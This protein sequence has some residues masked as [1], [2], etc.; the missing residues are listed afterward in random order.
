[1]T[2]QASQFFSALPQYPANQS[3]EQAARR[4]VK[5]PVE[6][7]PVKRSLGPAA[8]QQPAVDPSCGREAA[9]PERPAPWQE[10]FAN[11]LFLALSPRVKSP[12]RGA[13]SK[14]LEPFERFDIE[15]P[16]GRGKLSATWYPAAGRARGAVLLVHPWIHWGQGYFERRGRI[17]A[18]RTAGYH[19]LTFDLGGFGDSSP[20]ASTFYDRDI[21]HA[22]NELRTRAGGLPTHL[23]GVSSGGYWAHPVLSRV[24]VHGAVFEDVSQH[25]IEWSGRMAPWGKPCYAFFKY[26]LADAYRFM[27][28]KRHAPHL[29]ARSVGYIGGQ[30]DRG[31]LPMETCELAKQ[32]GGRTLLIPEADHLE[33]IKRGAEEVLAFALETFE[34]AERSDETNSEAD[35]AVA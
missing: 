3:T 34:L 7:R 6:R 17:G 32:A 13:P 25:L 33:A 29:G 19:A 20:M 8:T 23:W 22:L 27:D 30:L 18:L 5:R 2:Q 31:V 10:S 35:I 11:R 12:R 21:E 14:Y 4:S 1:M 9:P 15:R 26:V 28:L 16:G 24:A